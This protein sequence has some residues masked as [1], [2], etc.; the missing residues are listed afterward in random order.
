ME[1]VDG[2]PA[3]RAGWIRHDTINKEQRQIYSHH[4]EVFLKALMAAIHVTSGQP[5]RRPQ[6]L[7]LRPENTLKGALRNLFVAK[8]RVL[9]RTIGGKMVTKTG[10]QVAWRMLP[11]PLSRVVVVYL[12]LVVPFKRAL[13][14]SDATNE[15]GGGGVRNPWPFAKGPL[16]GGASPGGRCSYSNDEGHECGKDFASDYRQDMAP[17]CSRTSSLEI[18]AM[19]SPPCPRR[20]RVRARTP[21][22]SGRRQF[23]YL[24]TQRAISTVSS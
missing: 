16:F 15:G 18:V 6:I 24:T 9:I 20:T 23:K 5:V 1:R 7:S 17:S 19:P 2:D 10:E 22:T 11:G 3:L 4:V 21:V 14:A 8:G 12:A 13:D